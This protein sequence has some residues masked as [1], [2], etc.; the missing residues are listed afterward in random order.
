MLITIHSVIY[1][2]FALALL[3]A[4]QMMWPIYGVEINDQYAKFLSQHN[5]IFLGGIAI[6]CWLLRDT[7]GSIPV[8]HK[9]LLGLFWTN[10]LGV[11]ITLYAC[12]TG[13]FSGFGWSDPAFFGLLCVICIFQISKNKTNKE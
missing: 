10:A 4:P 1:A 8:A 12:L 7:L 9:V 13:V 6:L 11:A 2:I 5:S 3:L